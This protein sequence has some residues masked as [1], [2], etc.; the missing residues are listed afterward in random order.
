MGR[1]SA[2]AH[3]REGAEAVV[4]QLEN[5]VVVIERVGQDGQRHRREAKRSWFTLTLL[6]LHHA[7]QNLT[8][9]Q[10]I[11]RRLHRPLLGIGLDGNRPAD[12]IGFDSHVRLSLSLGKLRSR[13]A[14]GAQRPPRGI[15]Y[16]ISQGARNAYPLHQY[17][18]PQRADV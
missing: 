17:V 10:E 9:R 4:L 3:I 14:M 18:G 13:R 1:R 2:P 16:R 5:N 6:L 12:H 8:R 11:E 7:R 15:L